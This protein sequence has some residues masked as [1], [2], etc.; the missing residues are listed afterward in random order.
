MTSW[1]K[2]P[3]DRKVWA[4][5]IGGIVAWIALSVLQHYG[6]DPQPT[7]DAVTNVMSIISGTM[8][9][10]IDAA[11]ALAGIIAFGMAHYVPPAEMDIVIRVNNAIVKMANADPANPTTAAVVDEKASDAATKA[12]LAAGVLPTAIAVK[13]AAALP[14]T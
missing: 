13:A 2:W 6:I 14:G 5:G 8:V 4:G 11:A 1:L 9:P 3:P 12:D 10:H 7:V